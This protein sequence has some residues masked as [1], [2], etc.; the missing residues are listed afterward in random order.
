L[1]TFSAGE[2]M[3]RSFELSIP[4]KVIFGCGS[5]KAIGKAASYW[6]CKSLL[7]TGRSAMRRTGLLEEVVNS[8]RAA[9][10]ETVVYDNITPNPRATEVDEG[11]NIAMDKGCQVIIGL[12]GGSAIDA[13]KLIAVAAGHN[14]SI[15][16]Y[17]GNQ[18]PSSA[19]TSPI[20]AIPTTSGTGAEV[21]KGAIITDL[22][23]KIKTGV[24]GENL[25]PKVAIIDP[26][27]TLSVP[28]DIT[29]ET[30][31]DVLC[32]A[33]ETY[34]STKS[35][36]I[37]DMFAEKTI[38]VVVKNL[39]KILLNG[40]DLESRANM[41]YASMLMGF[42]L[43]NSRTCLPHRLQY[44][45]GAHT[46]T[47]HAK[48]LAAL[49]P[50]WIEKTCLHSPE[51]FA[52]IAQLMG[53]AISFLTEQEAAGKSSDAVRKF[54]SIINLNVRLRDLGIHFK[55]SL[56]LASEVTG[57][58]GSNPGL[59]DMAHIVELYQDSW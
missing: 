5:I 50:I 21:T 15:K 58:L 32:H 6:G 47:S 44:P 29:A 8:M 52:R 30:G 16:E 23:R 45:V 37:T 18:T 31:F 28:G 9:N 26:E 14:V 19:L 33:I 38:E 22:Q 43:I 39:P 20:I 36:P 34:V 4:T 17:I 12:G 54:L 13:A 42:N 11:A 3:I 53:E 2:S 7:V 49:L 51:K 1:K 35:Q 48:G 24:R 59:T 40:K 27:L 56:E 41:S 57:D 25:L 55:E 10:M 46:D